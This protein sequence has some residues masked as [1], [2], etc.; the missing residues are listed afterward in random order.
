MK[1]AK[2]II[3][4]LAKLAITGG[5]LYLVFNKIEAESVIAVFTGIHL[6]YML[7]AAGFFFLSK[8]LEAVRLNLFLRDEG[9]RVSH[10]QNFKLYLLGMFY[11]LFFPGGI[12]GD[13]YKVYWFKKRYPVQLK[14][15]IRVFIINRASGLLALCLLIGVVV[16]KI[17]YELGN[18]LWLAALI[19]ICYYVFYWSIKKYF[20][21][22]LPSLN[23]THILSISLQVVQLVSAHFILVSLGVGANFYDYWF[24][25]LV[26]GIAFILPITIGGVGAREVVFL[27]GAQFLLI[28]LNTAIALSLVIY[29]FRTVVSLT[30][31]YYLVF[32]KNLE[33]E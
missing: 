16:F 22:L 1:R 19:P 27:Y 5:A 28:D 15:L 20:N 10:K 4:L 6:G 8:I 29:L 26:S 9:I 11:N 2:S 25:Y 21:T 12:G 18:A 31:V 7:L 30:G 33:K 14:Q 24:I 17:S 32:P 13:S 3:K 23:A